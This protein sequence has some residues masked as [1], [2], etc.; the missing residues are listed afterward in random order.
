MFVQGKDSFKLNGTPQVSQQH[1]MWLQNSCQGFI[2]WS[3]LRKIVKREK[4]R[5]GG[6]SV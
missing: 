2:M 6:L 5:T 4:H 1:L 3:V